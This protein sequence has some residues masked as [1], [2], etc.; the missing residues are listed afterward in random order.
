MKKWLSIILVMITVS[1]CNGQTN[2]GSLDG[3]IVRIYNDGILLDVSHNGFFDLPDVYVYCPTNMLN[4]LV[5]GAIFRNWVLPSTIKRIGNRTY[6]G[7]IYD[8]EATDIIVAKMM[9]A[10]KERIAKEN[11]SKKKNNKIW[12][13]FKGRHK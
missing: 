10:D 13:D 2:F 1:V 4:N 12:N 8:K 7:Y 5:D 11:K 9:Q 3:K 6:Q